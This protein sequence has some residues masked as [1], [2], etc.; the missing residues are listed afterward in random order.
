MSKKL[1]VVLLLGSSSVAYAEGSPWLLEDGGANF[2]ISVLSG[3]TRDF[4]IGDTS[5]DLGDDL[6]GTFIWLNASY[7]YD[8]VWAFDIR[9]GYARSQLDGNIVDG[10]QVEQSDVN[11]T[12]LGVSYQ[13]LNEFEQDNGLPTVSGRIGYTFGGDYE[14]DTIDAIGDGASGFDVS[15]LVGKNLAPSF[16][17][18]GD[19][20]YRQRDDDVADAVKFLLSGNYAAPITGL[21]FQLGYGLIRTDSDIDIGGPGFGADQFPE[22]DKS[23]D[24]LITSANYGFSNGI[25][26]NFSLSTVLD[27]RN[28]ADTNIATFG[29]SYTL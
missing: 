10:E 2:G 12:S 4:F 15:L 9:T 27:G 22:T 29:L 18:S 25:G 17:L 26:I 13:F 7:G 19:L 14:T 11:D 5:M 1:L 21:S 6:E 24:W 28:I 3:S 16:S 20:T 23:S 8:D